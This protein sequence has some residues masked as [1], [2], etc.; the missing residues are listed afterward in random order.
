MSDDNVKK[1][2]WKLQAITRHESWNI[3]N[4][5]SKIGQMRKKCYEITQCQ[6]YLQANQKSWNVLCLAFAEQYFVVDMMTGRTLRPSTEYFH[7]SS[8]WDKGDDS[9]GQVF[10]V[11]GSANH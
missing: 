9:V 11:Q 2:M 7:F 5:W 6:T 4:H 8:K 3:W 1:F 10:T